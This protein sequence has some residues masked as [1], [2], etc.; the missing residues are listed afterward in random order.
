MPSILPRLVYPNADCAE[1]GHVGAGNIIGHGPI[2]RF[3]TDALGRVWA[4]LGYEGK[5][6]RIRQR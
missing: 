2:Y 3:Q 4:V 5:L 1:R 6:L